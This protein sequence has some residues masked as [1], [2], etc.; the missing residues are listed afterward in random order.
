[1]CKVLYVLTY[2]VGAEEPFWAASNLLGPLI[3]GLPSWSR[4]CPRQC[5]APPLERYGNRPGPF[6]ETPHRHFRCA[7]LSKVRMDNLHQ[8]RTCTGWYEGVQS[9]FFGLKPGFRYCISMITP[10]QRHGA[11]TAVASTRQGVTRAWDQTPESVV[12]GRHGR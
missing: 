4:E 12:G 10:F 2:R 8:L 3:L 6:A 1:M 11:S 5:T 9:R 7:T